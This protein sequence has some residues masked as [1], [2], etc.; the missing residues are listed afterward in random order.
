MNIN[1]KGTVFL[2]CP[3]SSV[4]Y[5]MMEKGSFKKKTYRDQFPVVFYRT[6]P[7]IFPYHG[8]NTSVDILFIH[9]VKGISATI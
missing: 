2:Y 9:S 7:T 4:N 8:T 5:L 1:I 3:N 6:Q